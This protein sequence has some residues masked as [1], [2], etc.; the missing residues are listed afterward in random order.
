[1]WQ[2]CHIYEF[3]LLVRGIVEAAES[4][5][6]LNETYF[7]NHPQI[8]T[9]KDVVKTTA[10]AMGK[11]RGLTLPVPIFLMR[12]VAPLAEL[13]HQ[14]TRS[15]PNIT[16]DKSTRVSSAVLASRSLKSEARFRLAGEIRSSDRHA[17][18]RPGLSRRSKD[19]TANAARGQL[20][21]LAQ[22]RGFVRS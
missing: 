12:L 7:L 3:C 5:K 2:V 10:Q 13:V 17:A 16:R 19:D 14:F 1:M 15:R 9:T 8:L 21:A 11:P 18:D 22:V 6:T 4:G 20:H